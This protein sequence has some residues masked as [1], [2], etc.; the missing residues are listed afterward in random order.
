MVMNRLPALVVILLS[1]LWLSHVE[2]QV[3]SRMFYLPETAPPAGGDSLQSAGS[4]RERYSETVMVG[5]ALID[6][7]REVI[8]SQDNP[9]CL[10]SVSCSNF[11]RLA[12]RRR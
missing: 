6:A 11:A 10:F 4:D 3:E 1:L 8:S 7:Y 9:A 2:A 5:T 12:I